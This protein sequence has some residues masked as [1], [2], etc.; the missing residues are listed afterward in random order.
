MYKVLIADDEFWIREEIKNLIDWE[1]IGLEIIG[2]AE[3]GEE[4]LRLIAA[5]KPDIVITDIKM[6]F[7]DGVKLL[8]AIKK[9]HGNIQTIVLSGYSDFDYVKN[10]MLFG[11]KDYLLKPVT[12][13]DLL[14]VLIRTIDHLTENKKLLKEQVNIRTKLTQALTLLVDNELSQ[15]LS[16]T[17]TESNDI[18]FK[19]KSMG[20]NLQFSSFVL[21][22]ISISHFNRLIQEKF[23]NDINI[24]VYA[25]G[26]IVIELS[27]DAN[28]IVFHNKGKIDEIIFLGNSDILSQRQDIFGKILVSLKD[29]LKTNINIGV[30]D[31]FGNLSQTKKAYTKAI[32]ALESRSFD[33]KSAVKYSVANPA[34]SNKRTFDSEVAN[35]FECLI[36]AGDD[37][38]A[39]KLFSSAV[40]NRENEPPTVAQVRDIVKKCMALIDDKMNE[41][42]IDLNECYLD[43]IEAINESIEAGDR[44]GLEN[45]IAFLLKEI[46]RQISGKRSSSGMKG[47]IEEIKKYI[48]NNYG[49]KLSLASIASVFHIEKTYLSRCFRMETGENLTD[50]IVKVRMQKAIELINAKS[51]KLA[52][53]A[54]LVGF[55]DYTYFNKVFKKFTGKS[56]KD[57]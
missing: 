8:E 23:G 43:E 49:S 6:P 17:M 18:L 12:Q 2:E 54:G 31:A 55:D 42:G 41:L 44:K 57:Y 5:G 15:L 3:N 7:M 20:I 48:A 37:I 34:G 50:Y 33:V 14:N 36:N 28:T 26:N 46:S 47:H 13:I 30:S 4:A 9:S 39:L 16:S 27:N 56:P 38:E 22:V 51:V 35:L 40:I 53:I 21:A 24:L 32:T 52:D 1:E 45:G 25:I 11:A 10:A 19:L 29:Y